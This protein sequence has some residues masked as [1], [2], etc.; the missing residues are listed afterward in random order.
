MA[1]DPTEPWGAN[2]KTVSTTSATGDWGENDKTVEPKRS[3]VDAVRDVAAWG[4]KSAIS[5]PETVVGLADLVSGGQ[6]G[7]AL[8]NEGGAVGFRPKQAREV[9]NEWHS[10]ATKLAQRRF[11][12]ADGI[13][14]KGK[15]AIENPSNIVGGVAESLGAM[16]A[17]GALARGFTAATRL[18]QMGVKG[19]TI[20]GAAGEG[21]TAAGSAAEQIRQETQDL[22]LIH[23]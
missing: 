8:E 19:A 6:A 23:I 14:A 1:Q 3:V 11:Q 12:E 18:G 17:G 13:V 15:A 21:V 16:G 2:D 7:K 10:D 9:V 4:V 5:V 22:S 20:A